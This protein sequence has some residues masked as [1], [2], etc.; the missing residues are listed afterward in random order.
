MTRDDLTTLLMLDLNLRTVDAD[1]RLQLEHLLDAAGELICREGILLGPEYS[2][3]DGHLVV[4]YASYLYRKRATNEAMPRM[5]R[6]ALNNRILS[7]K[8]GG[9]S[10]DE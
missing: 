6:W 7:E 5:L 3:E 10:A 2:A 1:R 4:M 9:G 8:A